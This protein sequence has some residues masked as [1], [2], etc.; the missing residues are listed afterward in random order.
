MCPACSDT[1][2]LV[3]IL[4]AL[5][6]RW[7]FSPSGHGSFESPGW[8]RGPVVSNSTGMVAFNL[9]TWFAL[10]GTSGAMAELARPAPLGQHS[11][12]ISRIRRRT[13]SQ[14]TK[15]PWKYGLGNVRRSTLI[16][17]VAF[18]I[19]LSAMGSRSRSRMLPCLQ[20]QT[21]FA[22][23]RRCTAVGAVFVKRLKN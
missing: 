21:I 8:L 10:R 5:Q 9:A 6:C 11:F 2:L 7:C 15:L 4:A 20:P 18:T 22:G 19:S 1:R 23:N 3:K 16:R 13:P 17:A 12:S 14:K